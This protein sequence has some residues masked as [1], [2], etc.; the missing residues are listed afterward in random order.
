MEGGDWFE[1]AVA[2][3]GEREAGKEEGEGEVSEDCGG[4]ECWSGADCLAWV[5]SEVEDFGVVY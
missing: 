4:E 5:P 2:E 1:E 3:G